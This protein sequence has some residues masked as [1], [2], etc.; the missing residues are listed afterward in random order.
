MTAMLV[1][2]GDDQQ[3]DDDDDG[4]TDSIDHRSYYYV[5]D[6][7]SLFGMMPLLVRYAGLHDMTIVILAVACQV[8]SE[9]H[10]PLHHYHH[11][12]LVRYV[13]LHDMTIV[14]L[15]VACQFNTNPSLPS[16]PSPLP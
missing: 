3:Y 12:L 6:V 14:L 11:H 16:L 5:A 1:N 13:G 15:A 2:D 7:V 9:H 10:L 4:D 8:N